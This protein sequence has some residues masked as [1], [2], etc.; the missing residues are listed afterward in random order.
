[1]TSVGSYAAKTHLPE[2]L[3][4]A[5]GGEKIL[6]TRRGVAVALLSPP[7]QQP[8]RNIGSVIA[9]MKTLRRGQRLGKGVSIR[10]L[11][12]DGRRS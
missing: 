2:L 1:M 4:R 7:P 10:D 3:A 5:E 12:E 9:Q 11:I 8:T 6:I